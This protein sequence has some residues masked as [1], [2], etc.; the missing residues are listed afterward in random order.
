MA[1]IFCALS[2]MCFKV[3]TTVLANYFTS[4]P[5]DFPQAQVFLTSQVPIATSGAQ[6]KDLL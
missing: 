4:S 6:L 2:L 1:H 5:K 3:L